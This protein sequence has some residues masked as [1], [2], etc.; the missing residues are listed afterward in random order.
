MTLTAALNTP[1]ARTALAVGTAAG[2]GAVAYNVEA[3]V[4]DHD[5]KSLGAFAMDLVVG[6]GAAAVTGLGALACL[7]PT[8][9]PVAKYVA[10][11]GAAL[12]GAAA[13]GAGS[14]LVANRLQGPNPA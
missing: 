2:I 9:R 3:V 7:S 1:L 14:L 10:G 8:A 6:G 5:F 12:T 4:N 11:V 13:L